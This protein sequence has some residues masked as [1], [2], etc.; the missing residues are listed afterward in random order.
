M[1]DRKIGY[2][3][4]DCVI[5]D[6][7]KVYKYIG[8]M[9]LSMASALSA[10]VLVGYNFEGSSLVAS[11]LNDNLS[12]SDFGV[13]G[14]GATAFLTGSGGTGTKSYR[15]TDWAHA[16]DDNPDDYF[17]FSVTV[18]QGYILDI[19]DLSFNSQRSADGPT[20]WIAKY[21]TDDSTYYDIEQG[22][23]GAAG[24]FHAHVADSLLP[25]DVTGT[26][27]FRIYGTNANTGSGTWRI[28]DVNLN[29]TINIDDGH[30][31]IKYQGFDGSFNDNWAHTTNAGS[32]TVVSSTDKSSS[33]LY[34]ERL[35][36]TGVG[37]N[38]DPAI[39]FSNID[40]SDADSVQLSIAFAAHDTLSDNDLWLDISYD[41]GVNFTHTKLMD[42]YG[43]VD[44]D[45]GETSGSNP[46]T[47]G[48]N[49]WVVN[50]PDSETEILVRPRYDEDST[51]NNTNRY[52]YVDDIKLSGIVEPG[53]NAP[54][55]DIYGLGAVDTTSA[56]IKVHV[57]GGYP[58]PEVKLFWGPLDGGTDSSAWNNEKSLGTESW[59]IVTNTLTGLESGQIYY[60]RA[61]VDNSEGSSWSGTT[62]NFA[63]VASAF[64]TEKA[65]YIDS[66][67]I[68]TVAP[69]CIDLDG[70]NM[71]DRWEEK[72]LGGTGN[73]STDD[74][75]SD[76]FNNL[77]ES[78]AGTDPDNSNSYLR[79][80]NFDISDATSADISVSWLGGASYG[81]SNYLAVG[82]NLQRSF[83]VYAST[84][85]TGTKSVVATIT[86]GM[87][88]TNSWVDT[89]AVSQY[90]SRYYEIAVSTGEGGYTNVEEWAMH[91]QPRA[92]DRRDL[93]CVPVDLPAGS[94]NLNSTL[95]MQLAR[96]LHADNTET[97]ADKIRWIDSSGSWVE[98]FLSTTGW[99][100]S[101]VG[102]ADVEITPGKAIWVVRGTGS[103]D[104]SN[105]V[106]AG[107]SFT[108]STVTNITFSNSDAGGWTMF[109]WPLPQSRSHL[110]TDTN[111][112]QL[113]FATLGTGGKSGIR[114]KATSGDE[115]WVW[116]GSHWDWYWLTDNH[117]A[118]DENDGRWWK[119][120]GNNWGNINFEVGKGYYYRHTTNWSSS[121]FDWTPEVP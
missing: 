99:Y 2:V 109:G 22:N 98:Y 113:G 18:G 6:K 93:I 73:L 5:S 32:A 56:E 28:D 89:N 117:A 25:F 87:S 68:D 46:T 71:S 81:P 101:G 106:F 63:T 30:R 20:N 120:D 100:E 12:A 47:V 13:G 65:V 51:D 1:C 110:A 77:E 121:N 4:D 119:G 27:Y 57:K 24:S 67:G 50:V 44:V 70:N 96:G 26:M 78:W 69:L 37:T 76:G 42:G 118:G 84:S 54:A 79:I 115:I 66:L 43:G 45:F 88:G 29:G 95:G 112:N 103:V 105:A 10:E 94:N 108:S 55:V 80:V 58:Y 21:S 62:T 49:P 92:A 15:K 116:N 60:L 34:S 38:A 82:D 23:E 90:S 48:S 9:L 85:P 83:R 86:D 7:M 104:R 36:G 59:G 111:K 102:L 41:N 64:S 39:T 61:Y 52:Y 91:V 72:Y 3:A 17:S 11:T 14:D 19:S 107:K 35:T 97:N 40:I 114:E 53:T 33:G 8:L 75:D 16:G 74:P 31:V